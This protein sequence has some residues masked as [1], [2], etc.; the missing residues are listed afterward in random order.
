MSQ[1]SAI[2]N[3]L[4]YTVALAAFKSLEYAPLRSL[5]GW[6]AA[7]SGCCSI[8]RFPR[9]RRTAYRNLAIA[10]PDADPAAQIVDGVFRS[11][12][13]TARHLRQFP[14]IRSENV[15]Q[16]IR[17]E[18][19]EHF[20]NAIAPAAAC[21]SRPRT[22]GNWELSAYRARAAGCADERG[23]AAARQSADRSRWWNS[24]ALFRAIG[25]SPRRISRARFSKALQRTRRSAF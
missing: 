20:E 8:W 5:T 24:A 12:A 21:C 17:C 25:R 14:S 6:P 3:G 4:E 23:G 7:M 9:L 11:I 2:R 16:W 18:G 13:R 19:G 1:R 10:L 22:S 15:E